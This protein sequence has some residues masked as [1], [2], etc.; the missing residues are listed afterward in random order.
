MKP[1]ALSP[2]KQRMGVVS[3]FAAMLLAGFAFLP[4]RGAETETLV[5][6]PIRVPLTAVAFGGGSRQTE[7]FAN[8]AARGIDALAARPDNEIK[9]EP[10]LE[11]P[12]YYRLP[13]RGHTYLAILDIGK[14][15]EKATLYVDME[16][17]GNFKDARSYAG[18]DQYKGANVS[19]TA[20][21]FGP[22][23][24][25]GNAESKAGTAG[26]VAT[27]FIE[28]PLRGRER[29]YCR[30]D[31][32][33]Y[34]RGTLTIGSDAYTVAF[35]DGGFSG[36][37]QP[38]RLDA[39]VS[40]QNAYPDGACF[41]AID[42]NKDGMFDMAGEV[43]HLVE[44]VR[45]NGAYYHV[46]VAADGS[47]A[48][49]QEEK[50]ALGI[51]DTKSPDMEVFAM[52]DRRAYFLT[53]NETGKWELPVGKY[54]IESFDRSRQE[55]GIKWRL[56]G[57]EPSK[58]MQNFEVTPAAPVVMEL[59][60]QLALRYSV[61]QASYGGP[62][63]EVSIGLEVRGKAGETYCA[64]ADKNGTREQPPGFTILSEAGDK[65]TEGQFEYG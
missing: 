62:V 27:I 65:L 64:G 1:S 21:K 45:I 16:G 2:A 3:I 34:L 9:S 36:K 51:L 59:G 56:E 4:A 37:Y 6:K 15:A 44:S 61:D 55:G 60:G 54:W 47:Q 39:P 31:P 30:L 10:A 17:K 42:F 58:A 20:F 63:R 7:S 53:A 28:K 46:N 13:T 24:F 23:E 25:S 41:M 33:K 40:R 43:S 38:A 12:L 52:S 50:P 8:A 11:N 14:G 49:F 29:P 22:I 35:V 26:A 19:E 18:V 32:E 48:E 5:G 57:S